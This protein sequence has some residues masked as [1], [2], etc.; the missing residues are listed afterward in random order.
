MSSS[1]SS[2]QTQLRGPGWQAQVG[3]ALIDLEGEAGGAR[4]D[5]RFYRQHDEMVAFVHPALRIEPT[6]VL[7]LGELFRPRRLP[8]LPRIPA[9]QDPRWPGFLVNRAAFE[10]GTQRG[11]AI[12]IG[13]SEEITEKILDAHRLLG[14]DRFFGQFDWGGLPRPL[15]EDST[16]RLATA[17]APAIRSSIGPLPQAA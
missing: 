14:I 16:H 8:L 4:V 1:I 5:P 2:F 7:E 17:I 12:M 15:V 13:S 10:A 3:S 9:A 6:E 11:N